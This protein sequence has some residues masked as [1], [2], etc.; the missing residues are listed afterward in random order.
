MKNTKIY[1]TFL[2]FAVSLIV[3]PQSQ[4]QYTQYMYNTMSINPAYTGSQNTLYAFGSYRSQWVGIDGAPTSQNIGV[5]SPLKN[6][7]I[8][9]GLNVLNES[10]G[11]ANQFFVDLNASYTILVSPT[12]NLAF[13]VKGGIKML[14]VDFSKG[15]YQDP[16]DPLLTQNIENKVNAILGTGAFLYSQNWYLGL[17]VPDFM[18][19]KYYKEDVNSIAKEEIQFFLTAGYVFDL[20]EEVKFKPALLARYSANYPFGFDFSTNFL[21]YEKLSLGLSY[22]HDDAVA[23][24][25]GF[26]ISNSF[27]LG[28]SFDY[29]ISEFTKYNDGT[30][31]VVLTYTLPMRD[32]RVNS[33][34]FF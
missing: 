22:R 21:F 17:S 27:F 11:P 24:L 5:H 29:S 31:E 18:T 7:A 10:L 9:V 4:P 34:R 6:E 20:S 13:G 28:Y 16:T 25:A 32:R 8:G 33:P 19:D 15:Y 30:H 1:I 12:T 23:A 14:N 2:L 26:Y 3:Y